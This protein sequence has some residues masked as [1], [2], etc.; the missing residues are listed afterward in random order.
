MDNFHFSALD[1]MKRSFRILTSNIGAF[2][3]LAL[4]VFLPL[5]I[6]AATVFDGFQG[7]R[8]S[9]LETTQTT[10][11][12]ANLLTSLLGMI[13]IGGVIHGVRQH[14]QG[15]SASFVEC[16]KVGLKATPMMFLLGLLTVVIFIAAMIPFYFGILVIGNSSL[17]I[18]LLAIL[19][20]VVLF[21][22]F[23]SL[24]VSGAAL[25]VEN[26][27]PID[28]LKR[29]L[30]LMKGARLATFGTIFLEGIVLAVMILIFA[31]MMEG[32]T[33]AGMIK[34]GS[35]SVMVLMVLHYL[36]LAVFSATTY[37]QLRLARGETLEGMTQAKSL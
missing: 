22:I 1:A 29:S 11:L 31:K 9:N 5:G 23:M 36:L 17:V 33:S 18:L 12:I 21:T 26:L 24:F 32:A 2:A 20:Y 10:Y 35:I 28:A 27:N 7:F 16:C 13:C 15:R 34:F 37:F 6:W 30:Q 14:Y 3:L 19:M 4:I 25:V 8:G